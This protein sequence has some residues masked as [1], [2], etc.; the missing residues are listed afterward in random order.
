MVVDNEPGAFALAPLLRQAM[1]AGRIGGSHHHG[2]WIDVGT[3]ERLA[4][5]DQRLR[6]R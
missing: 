6:S 4:R 1:A 5:L 3:P 2:A